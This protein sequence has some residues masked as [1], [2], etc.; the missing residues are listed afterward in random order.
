[1]NPSLSENQVLELAFIYERVK[2]KYTGQAT[3]VIGRKHPAKSI[4]YDILKTFGEKAL[5]ADI[6]PVFFFESMYRD[7]KRVVPSK[8]ECARI[9]DEMSK[10]YY[11]M[12]ISSKNANKEEEIVESLNV[13]RRNIDT[14]LAGASHTQSV[15]H[16]LTTL[17]PL[18]RFAYPDL[19]VMFKNN[20]VS[21]YLLFLEP[22]FMAF[23]RFLPPKIDLNHIADEYQR[24]NKH[25]KLHKLLVALFD[26]IRTNK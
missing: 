12:L 17:D 14:Y 23:Q 3:V 7:G 15:A 21:A 10:A 9:N 4:N 11:Q 16:L 13:T 18:G 26:D 8:P 19:A 1:M 22:A 25:G 24:Y 5:V 2:H 20:L 6:L